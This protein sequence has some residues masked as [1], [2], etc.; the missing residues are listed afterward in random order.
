M[1]LGDWCL[2]TE[3]AK[4][5]NELHGLRVIFANDKK[6]ISY[7]PD[8]FKNNPRIAERPE[9]GEQVVRISNYAGSRPYIRDVSEERFLWNEKFKARPGEFWLDEQELK[10]GI[11]DAVIIEPYVK[12]HHIFSQNK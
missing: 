7:H 2:A 3:E 10:I 8:I 11:E 12:N 1:G 4:Y 6:R 9:E 5:Y